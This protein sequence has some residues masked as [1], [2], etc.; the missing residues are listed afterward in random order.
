MTIT[1]VDQ[2]ETG[3]TSRYSKLISNRATPLATNAVVGGFH[4]YWRSAT[5]YPAQ[6][7][8]PTTTA[9]LTNLT[10]GA[11]PFM[12]QTSPI[13]SY[14]GQLTASNTLGGQTVEIH[15]RLAHMGGLNADTSDTTAQTVAGFDLDTLL[16]TSNLSNRI[17]DPNYSDVQ[18]WLEWYTSSGATSVTVTVNVT[19]ND[20]TTGTLSLPAIGA[21]IRNSRMLPLNSFI[22]AAASGKYI[23]AVTSVTVPRTGTNG[24]L[25]V[26]ATR[27]RAS[28]FMPS[29]N[30]SYNTIWAETGLPEIYN[31]SCLFPICIATATTMGNIKLDGNI[32]HG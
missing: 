1:T 14:L 4:S 27:Y 3:L 7:A 22:P 25:G 32:I 21:N 18:W 19:Y 15:D 17:G 24:N 29:A 30:K 10:V 23:R 26:T 11:I 8:I 12:Q 6:G 13:T 20:G 28:V 9:V 5:L 16:A 2:L 31:Q